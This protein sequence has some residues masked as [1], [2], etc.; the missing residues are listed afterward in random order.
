[1]SETEELKVELLP[2]DKIKN[3]LKF[4]IIVIGDAGVGKSCLTSKASKDTFNEK[5]S[6]TISFEFLSFNVKI[7]DK[8]IKLEIWDTCGQEVY[9]SLIRS[10]YTKSSLAMIVYS[11]CSRESFIHAESWLK[12]VKTNSNPDIKI[13]LIGNK[14]DLE[15]ER[16]VEL[17]EAKKFMEENGILYFSEASA[18]SGLNT[19]EIF[20]EAAKILYNEFLKYSSKGANNEINEE[21]IPIPV[22]LKKNKIEKKQGC[23]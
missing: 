15:E 21:N 19:K 16:E 3:D 8:I 4:K 14:A 2:P 1:M 13:F 17:S 20:I 23:C 5:Y 7:N 22:P 12:E 11:I 6:P 10:Y 9:Q 18:K